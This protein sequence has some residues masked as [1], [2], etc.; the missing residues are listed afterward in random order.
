M[1]KALKTKSPGAPKT[2]CSAR[3]SAT[4]SPAYSSLERKCT[5][6][7]CRRSTSSIQVRFFTHIHIF[8]FS[9]YWVLTALP[10]GHSLTIVGLERLRSGAI[11]LLV[12]DPMFRDAPSVARLFG[13]ADV[14]ARDPDK[15]LRPY[16]RGAKYLGKFRAFELL[17]LRPPPEA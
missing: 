4:S 10:P 15:L 6:P 12:F 1:P 7:T 9:L 3:S 13:R 14:R 17:R 2:A 11:N 8:A 5:A 16:R